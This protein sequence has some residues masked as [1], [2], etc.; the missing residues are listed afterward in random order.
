MVQTRSV[1]SVDDLSLLIQNSD[2]PSR[3]QLSKLGIFGSFARG[4]KSNDIDL[5]IEDNISLDEAL[6]LKLALEELNGTQIDIVLSQY[7]N[8]IVLHRAKKD[9]C[10]VE[11]NS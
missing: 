8:P 2:L 11:I 10:Y 1:Q 6:E 9:L 4:E 3:F 5:L 7:A